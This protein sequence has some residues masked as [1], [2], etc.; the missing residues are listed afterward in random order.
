MN[1]WNRIKI[2]RPKQLGKLIILL[3][4]NPRLV[5]P[6]I[7]ATKRTLTICDSLY[8]KKHH[9]NNPANAFRHA[10]WNMLLCRAVFKI[11]G[12]LEKALDWA[13]TIT[14]LHEEISFSNDLA[15]AMDLHN[16]AVG[17]KLFKEKHKNFR[18][19]KEIIFILKEI[20]KNAQQ[21]ALPKEVENYS[22]KLVFIDV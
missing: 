18:L 10:F 15:K 22:G 3:G 16:N 11:H 21:I 6:T 7:Q 12:D 5:F 4:R 9:R 20:A 19:E 2:L 13:K 17:R 1:L 14:D 8:G